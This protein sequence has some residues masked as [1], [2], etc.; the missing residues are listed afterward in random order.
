MTRN[1]MNSLRNGARREVAA[2][3][4]LVIGSVANAASY[5]ICASSLFCE[6]PGHSSRFV[7]VS[8]RA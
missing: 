8:G 1:R 5:E 2:L 7:C 3:L 6:K 4:F